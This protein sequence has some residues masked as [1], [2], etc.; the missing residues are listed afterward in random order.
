[1]NIYDISILDLFREHMQGIT[2]N[3]DNFPHF[4]MKS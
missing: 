4:K 2:S 3:P 1:M